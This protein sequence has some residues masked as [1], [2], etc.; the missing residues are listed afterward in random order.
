MIGWPVKFVWV[1]PSMVTASVTEG[2]GDAGMMVYGF[3]P[4]IRKLIKSAPGAS[5][6]S[7]MAC[8]KEPTPVLLVLRTVKV[9]PE[10]PPGSRSP[11]AKRQDRRHHVI[12]KGLWNMEGTTI[13]GRAR[14][15]RKEI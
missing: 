9:A 6:A 14:V 8:R 5:L 4:G 13:S 1:V 11:R 3:V 10:A 7:M 12:L 2:S 15:A